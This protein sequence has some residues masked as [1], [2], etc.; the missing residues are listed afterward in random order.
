MQE[1]EE[2]ESVLLTMS[3]PTVGNRFLLPA[4]GQSK[5]LCFDVPAPQKL[6]LLQD[7]ASEFSMN[8]QFMTRRQGFIQI[9]FHY[10]TNHH[11]TINTRSIRYQDGQNHFEFLW[12]QEPTQ[13]NTEGVSLILRRNEMDVTM[14]N[15][16]VVILLHKENGEVFLWPAVRQQPKDVSLRGILEKSEA[17]YEEVRGSQTPTLKIMDQEVKASLEDVTD[18]TLPSTPVIRCWLVPFQA[19]MQGDISDLTVT[20]L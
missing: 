11:L 7:S 4:A 15:I 2:E 3:V 6:R 17:S 9:A 18:Y 1:S 5:P 14:G 20:Q 13:H 8:G 10:K 12:D 19:V 16:R